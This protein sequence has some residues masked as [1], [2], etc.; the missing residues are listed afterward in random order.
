M[1]LLLN[2]LWVL[3]SQFTIKIE[4]W[5][6][7]VVSLFRNRPT[8]KIASNVTKDHWYQS[9]I[10][11]EELSWLKDLFDY[12][13]AVFFRRNDIEDWIRCYLYPNISMLTFLVL[14]IFFT[15]SC[16]MRLVFEF[17]FLGG[18]LSFCNRNIPSFIIL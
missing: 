12:S 14:F 17:C 4:E 10:A 1:S 18:I 6:V 16:I 2:S 8:I 9:Y 3:V 5:E 11:K 7:D 13:T 15:P